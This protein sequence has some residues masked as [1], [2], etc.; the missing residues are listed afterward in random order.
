MSCC[1][2]INAPED[3]PVTSAVGY[4]SL[5]NMVETDGVLTRSGG[6]P[7]TFDAVATTDTWVDGTSCALWTWIIHT[8]PGVPEE[9][10]EL[11]YVCYA[12]DFSYSYG[13][14]FSNV[15]TAYRR[16]LYN[17]GSTSFPIYYRNF[18]LGYSRFAI[19]YNNGTIKVY[20]TDE[21]GTTDPS[22]IGPPSYAKTGLSTAVRYRLRV[23]IKPIAAQ[24]WGGPI[25]WSAGGTGDVCSTSAWSIP[26]PQWS[27]A[28]TV[29]SE[30]LPD[31]THV[32]QS[33]RKQINVPN[34]V[35]STVRLAG[36]DSGEETRD[37]V[38][39]IIVEQSDQGVRR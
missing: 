28:A 6:N 2:E 26:V 35:L 17:N 24:A 16:S 29:V 20:E 9:G 13:W 34:S 33:P 30:A 25:T 1:P 8:N 21:L 37:E 19:T 22:W 32:A 14:Y 12:E 15:G 27:A 38:H 11:L 31:S 4:E 18:P 3:L 5:V 36:D 23:F 7:A 39:E 10:N